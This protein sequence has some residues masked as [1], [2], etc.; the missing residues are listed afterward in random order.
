MIKAS[1]SKAP[2][3]IVG[4]KAD[5]RS[6]EGL[7][8]RLKRMGLKPVETKQGKAI[9]KQLKAVHFQEISLQGEE[10]RE[11]AAAVFGTATQ[12]V[13]K[14]SPKKSKSKVCSVV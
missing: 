9:A 1:G 7:L 5:L 13:K 4:T 10:A 3:L 11:Y 8:T 14:A 12:H 6:N 2:L